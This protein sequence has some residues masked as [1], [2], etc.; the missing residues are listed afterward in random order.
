M[1]YELIEEPL[2]L[3]VT[4]LLLMETNG[5]RIVYKLGATRSQ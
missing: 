1:T 2:V 4:K 5:S 3:E